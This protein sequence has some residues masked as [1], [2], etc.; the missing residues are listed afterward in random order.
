MSKIKTLFTVALLVLL[1]LMG[2]AQAQDTFRHSRNGHTT[3]NPPPGW[4][5]KARCPA[6][7]GSLFP[8]LLL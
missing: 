4:V 2:A 1:G 6:A 5:E 3:P 7:S 8:P